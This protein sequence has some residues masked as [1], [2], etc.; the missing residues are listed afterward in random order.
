M[1]ILRT[2]EF[3][4]VFTLLLKSK[5]KPARIEMNHQDKKKR[6]GLL[7][8]YSTIRVL[9]F[10]QCALQLTDISVLFFLLLLSFFLLEYNTQR[11]TD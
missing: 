9:S 7:F 3:W 11:K 2:E 4:R 6:S 5:K 1:L 10:C 8:L